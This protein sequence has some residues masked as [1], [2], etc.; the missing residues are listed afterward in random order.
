MSVPRTI[1]TCCLLLL[2]TLAAACES[3]VSPDEILVVGTLSHEPDFGPAIE[4]PDS[5]DAGQAFT[6]IVRTVG[7]GCERMG[8]TETVADASAATVTPYDY[9]RD[10]GSGIIC[11][12]ILKLFQHEA[13]VRFPDAGQATVLVRAN[14]GTGEIVEQERA[15]WVR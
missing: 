6:V 15:V 9:T 5:V 3:P 10:R 7:S 11:D 4:V 12:A 8:P 1:S 14:D 2:L 13:S